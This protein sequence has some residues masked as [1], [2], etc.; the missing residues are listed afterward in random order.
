MKKNITEELLKGLEIF[1]NKPLSHRDR[2]ELKNSI[3][4]YAGVTLAGKKELAHKNSKRIRGLSTSQ[5]VGIIGYEGKYSTKDAA[6]F[7]GIHSHKVELDDGHRFAMMHPGSVIFSAL[8]PMAEKHSVSGEN[9]LKGAQAGY[10]VGIRVAMA[11]QPELK[12]RGFHG[13]GVA[14]TIGAAAGIGVMLGYDRSQLKAT[15]AYAAT[16]ASGLL[17]V[18]DDQ[19]D[20]KP[21]NAGNAALQGVLAAE[22]GILQYEGPEDIL[23]GKR[24]LLKAMTGD[25]E[26]EHFY[27]D[28]KEEAMIH[29]CYR[30]AYASCRHC[31][32]MMEAVIKLNTGNVLEINDIGEIKILTYQLAIEGHDHVD[33]KGESSAKMSIP[34]SVAVALKHGHGNRQLFQGEILM[35]PQV[36]ELMAKMRIEADPILSSWVPDKRGAKVTVTLNNGEQFTELVEYPK[37]EPEN[38]ISSSELESKF[39][40]LSQYSGVTEENGRELMESIYMI[41]DNMGKVID[42]IHRNS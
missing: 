13:T 18:I 36:H 5:G 20:L 8:F 40:S 1:K 34:Y 16:G 4:D 19:S 32:P 35:D 26:S 21:F 25:V 42:A 11:M 30:K 33:I 12:L 22:M 15:L 6:L 29:R 7:N 38:P 37:G 17:G 24:G 39:F 14:G 23:G 2:K 41:E 31:H 3:L 28:E 10:E 9:F 27:I